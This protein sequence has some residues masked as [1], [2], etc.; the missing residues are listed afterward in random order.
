MNNHLTHIRPEILSIG[1][2]HVPNASGLIKLD[3]MENPYTLPEDL[4]TQLAAHLAQVTLNRYPVP[5]YTTLKDALRAYAHIPADKD[6]MLGNGSDELIAMLSQAISKPNETVTVL[7]PAPSFV[8]YKMSGLFNHLNV[9]EIALNADDFS[10]DV[11]VFVAAIA[12]HKP[13]LVYL[14]FPNNPT[15]NLFDADA[16]RTIITTAK[17]SI[18]VVDEAYQPFALDTWMGALNEFDNLLVMRTVSKLG[19]A[20]IR[21]GYMAGSPALISELDKVRP[22]YNVNVLTEATTTFVLQ[23]ADVLTQQADSIRAE[24]TR[25]C[26]A[27]AQISDVRVYETAANFVLVRLSDAHDAEAVFASMRERGVLI[28]NMNH[29]HALLHNCLRITISTPEENTAMLT[30]LQAALND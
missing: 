4:K 21:L 18:V 14:P 28:K 22:P 26:A 19:L 27:L 30:A 29:A 13:A 23:H 24:R 16:M 25:V 8:M 17:D 12:Q 5:S 11:A 1:A 15:G 2:Y 9:V 7:A 3:A 6:I 10:L 20:G